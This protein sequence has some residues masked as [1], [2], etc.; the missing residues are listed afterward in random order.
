MEV[1]VTVEGYGKFSI[2]NDKIQALLNF[3]A[4]NSVRVNE[5]NTVRE[6]VDNGFTGRELLEE[7]S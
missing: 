4:S 6:V 7:R 1:K 5:S 2:Q 3:L